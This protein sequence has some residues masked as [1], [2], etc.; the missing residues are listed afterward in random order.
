[1]MMTTK[2]KM[3]MRMIVLVELVVRMNNQ[4][5]VQVDEEDVDEFVQ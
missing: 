1:M 3:T 2:K 4:S 5:M